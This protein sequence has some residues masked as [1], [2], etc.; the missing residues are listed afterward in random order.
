MFNPLEGRANRYASAARYFGAALLVLLLPTVGQ[1][2]PSAQAAAP[3]PAP[4]PVSRLVKD[5]LELDARR[6]LLIEQRDSP[7]AAAL[8]SLPMGAGQPPTDVSEAT[9]AQTSGQ[10]SE[11][12][13]A[14]VGVGRELSAIIA[15]AD[16]RWVFR[17]GHAAPISGPAAGTA[18]R[19]VR[20]DTP[21]A[22]FRSASDTTASDG[23]AI[24]PTSPRTL[25]LHRTPP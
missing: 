4:A 2:Q 25:C 12:L 11:R 24:E 9:A 18:L 13:Q 16:Q 15:S 14:I 10:S 20:I 22:V 6:A 7:N 19:L 17:S 21:C 8:G 5:I 3:A 1:A 23:P